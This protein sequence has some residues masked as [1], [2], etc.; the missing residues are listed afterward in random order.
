MTQLFGSRRLCEV[1]HIFIQFQFQLD[2]EYPIP[3]LNSNS[4]SETSVIII[5]KIKLTKY[6]HAKQFTWI[7]LCNTQPLM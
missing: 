4:T 3:I 7:V 2:I 5:K 6:L 1:L